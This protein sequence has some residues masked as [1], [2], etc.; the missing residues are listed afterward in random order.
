MI[1]FAF[2]SKVLQ[3]QVQP[4]ATSLHNMFNK[5]HI[6]IYIHI[7]RIKQTNLYIY[8]HIFCSSYRMNKLFVLIA[9]INL[10][11]WICMYI[12]IHV[13]VSC[14]CASDIYI[15]IYMYTDI[16]TYVHLYIYTFNNEWM[17]IYIHIIVSWCQWNKANPL[18]SPAETSW[19]KHEQI[20]LHVY[21]HIYIYT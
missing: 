4:R 17:C 15:Y 16:D 5:K 9:K 19:K 3:L 2:E 14:V 8:T 7:S 6:Y 11:L 18:Q 12:C 10:Y 20:V 13:R 21:M 1:F